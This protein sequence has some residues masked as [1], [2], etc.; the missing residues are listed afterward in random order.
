MQVRTDLAQ[1]P[2]QFQGE[3]LI[4]HK[5][6]FRAVTDTELC[7]A[8]LSKMSFPYYLPYPF[9]GAEII[10]LSRSVSASKNTR[11]IIPSEICHRLSRT[12]TS[13]ESG[14]WPVLASG[15]RLPLSGHSGAEYSSSY[16]TFSLKRKAFKSPEFIT[17]L[18]LFQ[19]YVC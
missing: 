2:L 3:I 6:N 17:Q 13:L 4:L 18:F 15:I 9:F 1:A 12:W 14:G 5:I 8:S 11:T 16:H 7:L 19:V 10:L